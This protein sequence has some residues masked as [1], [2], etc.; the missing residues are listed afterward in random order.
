MKN[1]I[2][3]LKKEYEILEVKNQITMADSFVHN[4]NKIESGSGEAKLYVGQENDS[5]LFF[6]GDRGF[7]LNSFI[8]KKDLLDFMENS[9]DEYTNPQQE[10]G[11]AYA[12][13]TGK[14]NIKIRK[15][16]LE[17]R[18]SKINQL[19]EIIYFKFEDQP[20]INPPRIYIK[21]EPDWVLELIREIALPNISYL[22]IMKISDADGVELFYFKLFLD[23]FLEKENIY[24]IQRIE[25]EIEE[26]IHDNEKIAIIKNARIGQGKYRDNLLND[27]PFCPIT[28]VSD[29]RVLIASHIKPWAKSDN[30]EK[31]D[32]KNGFMFSPNIDKL[33]DRGFIT[34]TDD[35]IMEASPW[36]S[37]MTYKRLNIIPNKKYEQLPVEG[38][39]K[40]LEYHRKNIFKK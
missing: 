24:K 25:E 26:E 5:N 38:R 30:K 36:L 3:I 33:F 15:E 19:D 17:E 7:S 35:K 2:K 11:K 31:I 22:S 18:I 27:C 10:Y 23:Y 21:T 9:E 13:R 37:N 32:S 4:T 20:Q 34:F 16:L 40:Y 6:L 1:K 14:R 39:E 28:L 8:L 29:E 12:K